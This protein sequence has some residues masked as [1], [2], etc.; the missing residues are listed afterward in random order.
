MATKPKTT[1]G[2]GLTVRALC[3]C[4]G[5]GMPAVDV[6]AGP[7]EDGYEHGEIPHCEH[8]RQWIGTR[9]AKIA[10]AKRGV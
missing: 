3:A 10:A 2:E 7:G 9:D 5:C 4:D 1:S 8:H 6:T